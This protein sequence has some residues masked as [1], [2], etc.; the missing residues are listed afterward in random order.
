MLFFTLEFNFINENGLITFVNSLF[1]FLLKY[2]KSDI[3]RFLYT[4]IL[5]S[6]NSVWIVFILS[7]IDVVLLENFIFLRDFTNS[8]LEIFMLKSLFVSKEYLSFSGEFS[9]ISCAA[10][11]SRLPLIPFVFKLFEL[12]K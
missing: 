6:F 2:W 1:I 8:F 10:I 4:L 11:F 9:I 12:S 3:N 5:L 7:C